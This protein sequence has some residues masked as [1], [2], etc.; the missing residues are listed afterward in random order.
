MAKRYN[1]R[2]ADVETTMSHRPDHLAIES[3]PYTPDSCRLFAPLRQ[4]QSAI[5]L[6]SAHPYSSRGRYDI[7]SAEPIATLQCRGASHCGHS[8]FQ[9]LQQQLDQLAFVTDNPL[10]LPFI[11]GALGYFSYDLGRELE[12]LPEHSS[13][14]LGLPDAGIGIYD[15]AIIVDHQRQ[16]SLLLS[17]PSASPERLQHI[18]ALLQQ[19][20]SQAS[21]FALSGPFQSNMDYPQY[22]Q[23]FARCQHYI[24]AG[25]C[26]QINLAQRFSAPFHGDSWPAYL[27][28]RRVAAAPYSAYLNCADHSIL[29]VSPEQFLQLQAGR[30]STAPIKGTA[31][32]GQCEQQDRQLALQL[33]ASRK[34]QAENLMIVDLLRNDLGKACR[35][36]S[37]QVDKLFELQSFE[38]V[39]HLVSTISGQLYADKTAVGLLADCFPG[40][41]ITGAPKVRAMEIIEELEPHRRSL[42]CGSIGYISVDGQME[43]NIAIRSL[44]A[45]GERIHCWA[46][47]GIVADS[48]CEGEYQES[49]NKVG[50]LLQALEGC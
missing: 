2:P 30:V 38:T 21:S 48:T 47:G 4:L 34:D 10:Q 31:P 1:R 7:I 18:K 37:I 20:H 32:R 28:L 8:F 9:R 16:Q 46:G 43:T 42:Y 19:G 49:L 12:Q 6:D 40:G 14:D 45:D 15:W 41:S 29:S 33:Q 5:F 22:Q 25:D 39:H 35:P 23:A 36:G 27:A 13:K 11:G 3:L 24:H 17:Q 26:Y 50:K 44:V